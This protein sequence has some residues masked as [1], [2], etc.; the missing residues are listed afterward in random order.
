MGGAYRGRKRQRCAES[1]ARSLR[2]RRTAFVR[3]TRRTDP[4]A[5]LET[6]G[7]STRC[8]TTVSFH[9]YALHIIHCPPPQDVP[10]YLEAVQRIAAQ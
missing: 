10:R 4:V 7:S 9:T 2:T 3:G 6:D 8:T 1:A 5:D